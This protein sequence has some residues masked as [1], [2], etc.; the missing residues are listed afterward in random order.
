MKQ[1]LSSVSKVIGQ[2][3][4]KVKRDGLTLWFA[5]RHAETPI[6]VRGLCLL[7]VAYALSPIDLIPD[8]I[9]VLGYVDD[10]LLLPGLIW[11]SLR[12]L[13]GK[14]IADSRVRADLWFIEHG[15]KP[16]SYGGAI[17]IAVIWLLALY[18]GWR[19]LSPA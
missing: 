13:P 3:A 14:V 7:V 4:R 11:L 10:A 6:L 17:L 8:F 1:M 2:W 15:R 12:L 16:R 19:W 9:P 18:L 5:Y